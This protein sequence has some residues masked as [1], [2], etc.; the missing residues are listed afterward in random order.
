[1]FRFRHE[2]QP[3]V[4]PKPWH[5]HAKRCAG[6]AARNALLGA[7]AAAKVSA[8]ALRWAAEG[9]PAPPAPPKVDPIPV[10]IVSPPPP[11]MA[12]RPARPEPRAGQSSSKVLPILAV[13]LLVGFA[14][15][16]SGVRSNVKSIS[17]PPAA[18][19]MSRLTP[20][21]LTDYATD[22]GVLGGARAALKALEVSAKAELTRVPQAVPPLAPILPIPPL[23]PVSTERSVKMA[24]HLAPDPAAAKPRTAVRLTGVRSGEPHTNKETALA[25]ALLVA[26]G[27]L[28][29]QFAK[30]DP[31]LEATP[32]LN[33]I[34]TDYLR[35]ESVA[36]VQ[37]TAGDREAWEKAGLDPR[38][39]WVTADVEVSED[40]IRQLRGDRRLA[41]AAPLFLFAL[42]IVGGL[43]GFLR[44]DALTKGHLTGVLLLGYGGLMAAAVALAALVLPW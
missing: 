43:Y 38:R 44:L 4:P 5:A 8:D 20:A 22:N 14:V 37:A 3:P 13:A 36:E 10:M 39:F 1:M 15:A 23:P 40:Q 31:P 34:R 30:L 32:S 26:Q 24:L 19:N 29:D 2:P 6:S 17:A 33:Q 27:R 7:A 42:V 41:S 16:L 35:P 11:V 9:R 21:K 28:A 25:D 18:Q 12:R